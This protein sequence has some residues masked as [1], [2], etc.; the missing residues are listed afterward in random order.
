MPTTNMT[1]VNDMFNITCQLSTRITIN[2]RKYTYMR[3]IL[4][5]TSFSECALF[6]DYDTPFCAI[7]MFLFSQAF[8]IDRDGQVVKA[9]GSKF[10]CLAAVGSNSIDNIV[11]TPFW[12]TRYQYIGLGGMHCLSAT[13]L[14]SEQAP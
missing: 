8:N 5:S 1:C 3:H 11:V 2:P 6:I 13:F 12:L 7:R 9:L 10:K 14:A 4:Q